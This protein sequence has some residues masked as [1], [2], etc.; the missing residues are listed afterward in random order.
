MFQPRPFFVLVFSLIFLQ[1]VSTEKSMI[2]NEDRC[3]Q[4]PISNDP[5]AEGMY[6]V[7]KNE[8]DYEVSFRN[9]MPR[10]LENSFWA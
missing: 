7:L 4:Y 1:N 5:M 3:F 10:F 9:C 6:Y 2:E 8:A